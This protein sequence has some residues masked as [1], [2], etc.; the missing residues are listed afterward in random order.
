MANMLYLEAP[1][2]VGFSYSDDPSDYEINDDQTALDNLQALEIFF[3]SFPE[4]TGDFYIT[5]ESYAGVYV[6]TLAEAIMKAD[7]NGLYFGPKLKGIAVG[8]GC[9]GNSLGVCGGQRNKYETEYLLGTALVSKPLKLEIMKHC[10]FDGPD[11]TESIPCKELL[12]KMSDQIGNVN[13]YDIYGECKGG[14][15]MFTKAPLGD[16][17]IRQQ[18]LGSTGNILGP[19][20]C[21]N[22]YEATKY[23][24]QPSVIK[25]LH[26][27][28]PPYVWAV[29]HNQIRYTPNR[30]NL[31]QD[32]YPELVKYTRVIIY[33]GDWDSCVPY[34][35][36]EAWTSSM[37]FKVKKPWHPWLYGKG[38]VGGYS[39]I[40]STEGKYDFTFITIRGGRHEVPETSPA[41]A[42]EMI[43]RLLDDQPF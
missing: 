4:K 8:N 42:Y 23:L 5:G 6:P 14:A 21:I 27:K 1:V 38:Q 7:M 19:V 13:L 40:Y 25:A 35:D 17:S 18:V 24:T 41:K 28:E 36:N 15:N 34:T 31:P 33:N 11:G 2:G 39:T 16:S 10:K 26:V 37:G 3:K 32:T 9:T 20:P 22:S 12:V 43:R 29:C 30:K